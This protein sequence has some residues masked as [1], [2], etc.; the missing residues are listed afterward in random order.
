[1]SELRR[2]RVIKSTGLWYEVEDEQGERWTARLRGKFKVKG[3]K[4]TNPL[5][6]GDWVKFEALEEAGGEEQA[7]ITE[8]EARENYL[9]RRS[10]HN[11]HKA[12][13]LAANLDQAVL[14]ATLAQPRTS[15][16]F[17]DRFLVSAE[18]YRIPTA[19]VFNKKDLLKGKGQDYAQELIDIYEPLGYKC[20]F[21]SAK[22]EKG[23]EAFGALLQDKLSLLSGHSGV[24]KSTLLNALAPDVN[25]K[26]AEISSF[27]NKGT[28]TTTFAEMFK[29]NP[30]TWVIDTPG[31]K[32][33]G[34]ADMEEDPL[35]HY[36]PEM[37]KLLGECRFH[38]CTH[39]H[40]PGCAVMDAVEAGKISPSRYTSYLGMLEEDETHR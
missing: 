25:Q 40:E 38:N 35:D 16:G 8:I 17:I 7:V 9:I 2:G 10:I 24:G 20:I 19:I 22:E 27:A 12:H 5:A 6:V 26:T 33:L 34:L 15:L 11:K 21:I 18:A 13:I 1:M 14:I 30:S 4:V 36:F 37:R 3:L 39:T 31:I 23:I 28:H 29:V 32:E